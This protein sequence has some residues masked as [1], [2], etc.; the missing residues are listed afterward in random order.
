[1]TIGQHQQHTTSYLQLSRD[2]DLE[3]EIAILARRVCMPI[4][5]YTHRSAAD[6][7]TSHR[8]PCGPMR[9]HL[10]GQHAQHQQHTPSYLQ[11]LRDRDLERE[12]AILARCVCHYSRPLLFACSA[13]QP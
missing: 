6:A 10:R 3:R 2:R 1:M 13:S 5:Y 12:I 11:L 7:T 4:A 8:D 9:R